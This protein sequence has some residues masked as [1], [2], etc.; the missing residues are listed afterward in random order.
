MQNKETYLSLSTL[1]EVVIVKELNLVVIFKSN[2]AHEGPV[3]RAFETFKARKAIF[4]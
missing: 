4:I 2:I 1:A 3:S